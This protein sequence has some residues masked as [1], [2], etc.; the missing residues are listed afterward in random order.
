VVPVPPT[1]AL[2]HSSAEAPSARLNEKMAEP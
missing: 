1:I 2:G